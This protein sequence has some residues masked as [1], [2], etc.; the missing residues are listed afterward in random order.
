L[1]FA[2][3]LS[4]LE[5]DGEEFPNSE[6]PTLRLLGEAGF[7]W[8]IPQEVRRKSKTNKTYSQNLILNIF[9]VE[10]V[11]PKPPFKP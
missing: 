10:S 5:A 11:F 7:F 2:S 1:D 6:A 9:F 3:A 4:P 8:S